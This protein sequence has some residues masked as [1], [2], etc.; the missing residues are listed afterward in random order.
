MMMVMIM[1][2]QAIPPSHQGIRRDHLLD[3]GIAQEPVYRDE[4]QG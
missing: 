1:V 3:H 2:A 4:R